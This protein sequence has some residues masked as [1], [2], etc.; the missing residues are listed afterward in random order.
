[1]KLRHVYKAVLCLLSVNAF[2]V[3]NLPLPAEMFEVNGRNAFVMQPEQPAAGNP[4]VW[5]APTLKNYP[6]RS[7]QFYFEQLLEH[8]IAVAGYDLGE[9]RGAPESSKNFTGFYDAMVAK[10]YSS[11][12]VLLGQSRGGLMML[13]WAF[14]N[15][16]KVGAFAGIYPVCNIASWP[17]KHSKRS[18]L[19]D[20]GMSEEDILKQLDSFNP[21]GNLAGLAAQKVPMF[22]IHGD[23]DRVVP[24]RD[25]SELIKKAYEKAGGKIEVKIVLGKGHAEIPECFTDQDLLEFILANIG[26]AK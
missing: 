2:A 26:G 23:S 15:P 24:S 21:A 16:D 12:P 22:I 10:G 19:R 7:Q 5:Y 6:H 14:R 1:M 4:W 9:V 11:K 13:C 3:S 8:G 25:N 20:Y 17:L 18:V